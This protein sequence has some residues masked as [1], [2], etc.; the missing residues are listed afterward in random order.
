MGIEEIR[1]FIELTLLLMN[2]NQ[3]GILRHARRVVE[4]FD[5]NQVVPRLFI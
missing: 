3:F 4:Y 2:K 1:A 5:R